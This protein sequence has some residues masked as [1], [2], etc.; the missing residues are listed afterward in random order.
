MT[1]L[2]LTKRARLLSQESPRIYLSPSKQQAQLSEGKTLTLHAKPSTQL[3]YHHS[4]A[5]FINKCIFIVC[6]REHIRACV[7][8]YVREHTWREGERGRREGGRRGRD[9]ETE[10]ARTEG[11]LQE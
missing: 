10:R 4:P 7:C 11:N 3:S 6:V 8:V 9:I 2:S 1:G 5:I